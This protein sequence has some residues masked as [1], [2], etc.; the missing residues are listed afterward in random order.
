MLHVVIVIMAVLIV[1][2]VINENSNRITDIECAIGLVGCAS[3]PDSYCS[4]QPNPLDGWVEECAESEVV[5]RYTIIEPYTFDVC[6]TEC[7]IVKEHFGCRYPIADCKLY[8]ERISKN[9]PTI[10]YWNETI[11]T[12]WMLVK[13]IDE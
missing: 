4:E 2:V 11:C 5:E 1:S 10:E 6:M 12:K 9:K 3:P 8:C 13:H 7:T